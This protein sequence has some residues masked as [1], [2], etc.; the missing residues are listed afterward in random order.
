TVA[1]GV[2]ARVLRRLLYLDGQRLSYR[3]LD[4]EQLG[5]VYEGLMGY[6]VERRYDASVCLRPSRVWVSPAELLD[7]PAAT[8]ARWLQD[9]GVP[10]ATAKRLADASATLQTAHAHDPTA[11][12]TALLELLRKESVAPPTKAR[13]AREGAFVAEV[14][15]G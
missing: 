13:R 2:L 3:A 14:A 4:E 10:T 1:D 8:R 9:S 11:L 12:E 15:P 6:R 7:L 5:S